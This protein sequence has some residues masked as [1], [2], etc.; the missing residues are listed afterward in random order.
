[1]LWWSSVLWMSQRRPGIV[2]LALIAGS[3]EVAHWL[4]LELQFCKNVPSKH[5]A[6]LAGEKTSVD[7]E[8]VLWKGQ[9]IPGTVKLGLIAAHPTGVRFGSLGWLPEGGG[10]SCDCGGKLA[11]VT[12]CHLVDLE[13]GEGPMVW[14]HG[15]NALDLATVVQRVCRLRGVCGDFVNLKIYRFT[16]LEGCACSYGWMCVCARVLRAFLKKKGLLVDMKTNPM[17]Y[18]CVLFPRMSVHKLGFK[19]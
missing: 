6:V 4:V 8:N 17:S 12:S 18:L 1:M 5:Q 11:C 2:N 3:K 9:R 7:S 10:V 16:L 14:R 19:T 15:N 13:L